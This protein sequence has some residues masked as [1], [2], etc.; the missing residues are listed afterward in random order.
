MIG[1]SIDAAERELLAAHLRP[2]DHVL[3]WGSG[4]STP[5]IAARARHV[6]TVEH[7]GPWAS[8]VIALNLANVTVCHVQ[9]E[10]AWVGDPD[11][12]DGDTFR[13]YV[14]TGAAVVDVDVA[15]IDGRA[16]V[17][18]A[19]ALVY[20]RRPRVIFV[21]DIQRPGYLPLFQLLKHR[22]TVARLGCFEVRP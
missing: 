15:V 17:A 20:A 4:A 9:P 18:C 22:E 8:R 7:V 11:E 10:P 6:T 19:E 12:G 1:W 21:H 3:E 5:W 14:Q 13:R 16:R 2:T